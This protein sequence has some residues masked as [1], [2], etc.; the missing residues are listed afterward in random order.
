[1]KRR[2]KSNR[3]FVILCQTS[4]SVVYLGLAFKVN[5]KLARS[6][7]EPLYTSSKPCFIEKMTTLFVENLLKK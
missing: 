6:V 4:F 7:N 3:I 5:A 1:M 2:S